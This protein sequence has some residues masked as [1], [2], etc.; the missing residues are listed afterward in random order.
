MYFHISSNFLDLL[1]ISLDGSASRDAEISRNLIKR[2]RLLPLFPIRETHPILK[3]TKAFGPKLSSTQ[4][5]S[6]PWIHT[7]ILYIQGQRF[8]ILHFDGFVGL[9]VEHMFFQLFFSTSKP[10]SSRCGCC[11]ETVGRP[12]ERSWGPRCSEA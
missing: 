5:G 7:S 4:S 3:Q 8:K 9:L 1:G 6:G 11:H 2:P 12:K 10:V